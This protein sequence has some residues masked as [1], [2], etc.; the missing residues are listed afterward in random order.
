[1][2]MDE[3]SAAEKRLKSAI[4]GIGGFVAFEYQC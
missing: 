3:G 1:M 4:D 2:K